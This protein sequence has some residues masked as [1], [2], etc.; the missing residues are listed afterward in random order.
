M[1][2]V[3][4]PAMS[5]IAGILLSALCL[6]RIEAL[7]LDN[8]DRLEPIVRISPDKTATNNDYFGWAAIFHAIEPVQAA[9]NMEDSLRKIR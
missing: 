2:S 4:K 6:V 3:Y 9:D 8:V 1:N 7:N 5:W